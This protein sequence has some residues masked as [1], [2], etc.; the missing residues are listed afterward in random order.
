MQI[1]EKPLQITSE[2]TAMNGYVR[3]SS[4]LALLQAAAGQSA[5]N[6]GAGKAVTSDQG[7]LWMIVHMRV[8]ITR[9]PK[10]FE[11]VT[12]RT[13][14]G[15]GK[16]G[17]YPRYYELWDAGENLIVAASGS[18]VLVD[19]ATR[20]LLPPDA[21]TLPA[22]VTGREISLPKRIRTPELSSLGG[23]TVQYSQ[24]D[25]N[26]HMNNAKYL[27]A[28]ED[29]M[30]VEYLMSH[31]LKAV[32]VDYLHEVIPGEHVTLGSA[33]I[34]DAWYFEGATHEP[35]FRVKLEYN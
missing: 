18:W 14:P 10:Y 31:R 15:E 35:C 25:I 6:L 33:Q 20:S 16:H 12:I 24:A 4:L 26:G 13:W 21:V 3:T 11:Q 22:T 23:F 5:E 34:D 32:S 1:Y 2:Y 7:I 19:A 28:V 8:E 17:I 30:P 9:L 29:A 27:D